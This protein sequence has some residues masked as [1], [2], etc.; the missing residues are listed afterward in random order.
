MKERLKDLVSINQKRRPIFYGWVIVIVCFVAEFA[1]AIGGSYVFAVFLKPMT[2][3]FGWTRATIASGLSLSR[4]C[5]GLAGPVIGPFVDRKH[6][7][8]LLMVGGGVIFGA[9]LIALGHVQTL[10]QYYLVFCIVG[11]LGMSEA[12]GVV[13]N[14]VVAKWF[15]RRR[16]R[17][18]AFS[19]VGISI[20]GA[21]MAM[22]SERLI[23]TLGWRSAWEVLG[24]IVWVAIIPL[25]ALFMKRSPEDMGLRPDGEETEPKKASTTQA[26]ALGLAS[27]TFRGE[28]AWTLKQVVKTN[29]FWLIVSAFTVSGTS[30]SGILMHHAAYVTDMGFS[31][32]TAAALVSTIALGAGLGKPFWGLVSEKIHVRYCAIASFISTAMAI[33]ILMAARNLPLLFFSSTIYGLAMGGWVVLGTLVYANYFGRRYLG[34]IRGLVSPFTLISIAG[35]PI[36]AGHIYD[37]TGNYQV[38]F[39]IIL[40]CCL[41]GASLMFFAKPPKA[42]DALDT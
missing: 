6:G 39:M 25:A 12:G 28:Q 15:I 30:L 38:S 19:I 24:L 20:G 3:E 27:S 22:V 26:L 29:T 18:V 36:L 42:P 5:G 34:A 37:V 13:S 2:A 17:A 4:I 8:R 1:S 31:A 23:S 21:V 16:G 41:I 7:A 33:A 11:A 9:G 35:G 10:W 40:T 14:T 32:T